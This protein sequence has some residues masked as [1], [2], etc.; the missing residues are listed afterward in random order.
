ML[1]GAQTNCGDVLIQILI[2]GL[3]NGAV[4]ALNAISITVIYATVRTLNLAHGDLFA[5]TTV[6]VT[7]VVRALGLQPDS[8]AL[9]LIGGLAITLGAGM[10]FGTG[11]S[12]AI[13]RIAFKPFRGRSRLAPLIATLGISFMLFQVSMIWRVLMPSWVWHEHRSVPGLNEVP[14]DG[15]PNLLPNVNLLH[16]LGLNSTVN[17]NFSNLFIL[18]IAIACAIGAS[19]YLK[20]SKTG[21]AIRASAQN[22][23]LAQINGVNLDGAIRRAFAFGGALAGVAGF[24]FAMY[25]TRPFGEAGAES[26]LMAFAAAILGGI[27]SPIGA[28]VASMGLGIFSAFSDFFLSAQWTPVLLLILFIAVLFWR[29]TGLAAEESKEDVTSQTIRDSVILTAPGKKR[30]N[31]WLIMI[32]VGLAAF[33]I[34]SAITSLGWQS[35]VRNISIYVLLALGLNI[36][37]GVAGILDLGFAVSFGIGGYTVAILANKYG[38]IG[39]LIP[40]PIDFT[41]LLIISAMLAGLYG[42]FKGGLAR[43]LHS[44]YL[45]VATLALGLLA[46]RVINNL[47]DLTGG[48]GGVGG[49]PA[50]RVFSMPIEGQTQQ[51]YFVFVFVLIIALMVQRLIQSRLGRAWIAASDDE[52]AAESNGVNIGRYKM[53]A[54]IVSSAI[55]G[56]AGALYANTFAYVSPDM[57]AFHVSALTLAMVILGGAGS[58]P[59]AVLGAMLIISYDQIIIPQFAAF[60]AQFWPTNSFIGSVPDLRGTSFFNFGL[61]LYLTVWLRARQRKERSESNAQPPTRRW[62]RL[63]QP[64]VIRTSTSVQPDSPV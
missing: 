29:P 30:S 43:R 9:V 64:R 36:L 45:A 57:V 32:F 5:L 21:R 20:R 22:P 61:A 15:I 54:M 8:S 39:S 40:Q 10:L 42:A 46:E 12:I 33:P 27:G 17:F 48:I 63:R 26:G 19:L 24:I 35:L 4:L 18:T 49:L 25:Y 56:V 47:R 3:S 31:R 14:T 50:P 11:L 59:G 34:I 55:A 7:T 60:V 13:D 6:V 52:T 1:C 41:I 23:Q 58:V 38:D 53:L 62:F 51:Y 28:L 16:T 37:L 44:D 2:Y